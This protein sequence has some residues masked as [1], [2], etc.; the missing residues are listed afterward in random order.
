MILVF[1][2]SGQVAT[3]LS[4]INNVLCI[5]REE[6]NFNDVDSCAKAIK[7]YL[8]KAV[9]NAAAY[10]SVDQAE[11]EEE[12]AYQINS[13]A[14]KAMAEICKILDI[15][16]IHISTDY[17][18]DGSGHLPWKT[19][20]EPSPLGAYGRSKYDGEKAVMYINPKAIILRTSWIFSAIGEN[21]V[22][23]MLRLSKSNSKLS[24]VSDQIGGPTSARSV[25]L[26]CHRIVLSLS[27]KNEYEI[28]RGYYHFSGTPDVSWAE[29]A[30]EIFIQSNIQV[31]IKNITTLEYPTKASRPLNS[32]L[33]CMKIEKNFRI[34]RPQWRVELK[35]ILRDIDISD[36]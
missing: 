18:F 32:R 25:A 34:L 3:E 29:F 31:F 8:P 26:A 1:G 19:N 24:I 11:I 17:V 36:L 4:K 28:E 21:F 15:L 12:L 10:T 13:A 23:S 30:K 33:D 2:K 5:G 22:K 6:I 20:D 9:I 16:F 35:K 27:N 14:P 7:H